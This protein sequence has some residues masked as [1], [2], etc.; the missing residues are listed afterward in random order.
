V[1]LG[2]RSCSEASVDRGGDRR[3]R[4]G[5]T[6]CEVGLRVRHDESQ[7]FGT[8]RDEPLADRRTT[9]GLAGAEPAGAG[10]RG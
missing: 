6:K 3:M 7:A 2:A 8:E 1:D 9:G 4:F 5:E 10:A